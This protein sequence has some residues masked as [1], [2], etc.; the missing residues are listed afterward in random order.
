MALLFALGVGF[1]LRQ[2]KTALGDFHHNPARAAAMVAVKTNPD[3]DLVKTDDAA[4]EITV[5]NRQTGEEATLSFEEIAKG[6]FPA[7]VRI[8]E[9]ASV[10][11]SG[12]RLAIKTAEAE[13]AVADEAPRV[14]TPAWVP[15]YPG[16]KLLAGGTRGEKKDRLAGAFTAQT[17]DAP[18]KV[19]AF[20]EAKLKADGFKLETTTSKT[21]GKNSAVVS[22]Q[23]AA[24][25][26]SI[27]VLINVEKGTTSVVTNYEEPK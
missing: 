3:F 6:Q 8:V 16:A 19:R 22:A 15:T 2:T 24:N 26:Q 25:R 1:C 9:E 17:A 20:F 18:S 11:T 27:T 10:R 13:P 14:A 12:G 4:G 21:G 7:K 5:R 23:K